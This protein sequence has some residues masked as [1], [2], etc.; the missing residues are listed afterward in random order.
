MYDKIAS[1]AEICHRPKCTHCN[2]SL[3]DRSRVVI[4]LKTM[5]IFCDNTCHTW[6]EAKEKGLTLLK[7]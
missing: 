1:I 5:R 6:Q 3:E 7:S 4:N 2:K